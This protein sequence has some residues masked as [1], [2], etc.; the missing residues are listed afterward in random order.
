[1]CCFFVIIS[2]VI[3]NLK[4]VKDF[5]TKQKLLAN[6]EDLYGTKFE[7]AYFKIVD[8]DMYKGYIREYG[9]NLDENAK[10]LF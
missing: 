1:L 6:F 9:I 10:Y 2:I 5:Y 8:Y 4:P 7:D 3:L